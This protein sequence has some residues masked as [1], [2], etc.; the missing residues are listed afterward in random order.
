MIF[1]NC[2]LDT[3]E[4]NAILGLVPLINRRKLHI[5]LLTE[6]FLESSVPPYLND[7]HYLNASVHTLS[8]RRC[9]DIRIPKVNLEVVEVM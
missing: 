1:S 5:V 2:N 7:Y 3:K 9:D 8:T 4:L 6:K